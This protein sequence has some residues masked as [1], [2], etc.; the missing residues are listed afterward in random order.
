MKV[1]RVFSKSLILQRDPEQYF[2]GS[3]VR[4]LIH[5]NDPG[6]GLVLGVEAVEV[7][8]EG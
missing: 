4:T 2:Q 1:E 6:G 8:E 3:L 5:P 7:G